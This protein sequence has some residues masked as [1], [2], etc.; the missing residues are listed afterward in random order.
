MTHLP[1]SP[2]PR[3]HVLPAA[4]DS[5]RQVLAGLMAQDGRGNEASDF[6]DS[7]LPQ[8]AASSAPTSPRAKPPT[9]SAS[10]HRE[11]F[12][13][14]SSARTPSAPPFGVLGSPFGV[15]NMPMGSG[16]PQGRPQ[17]RPTGWGMH[18][19]WERRVPGPSVETPGMRAPPARTAQSGAATA[20]T[21]AHI[22]STAHT[23]AGSGASAANG[24]QDATTSATASSPLTSSNTKGGARGTLQVTMNVRPP[25]TVVASPAPSA[26]APKIV[27]YPRPPQPP[28]R[29]SSDRSAASASASGPGGAVRSEKVGLHG[30]QQ[31]VE[32]DLQ[33]PICR[34]N[35]PSHP[36]APQRPGARAA[37]PAP[38]MAHKNGDAWLEAGKRTDNARSCRGGGRQSRVIGGF[39]GGGF[40]GGAACVSASTKL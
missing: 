20:H 26:P 1:P 19:V 16:R 5:W 29:P 38:K 22:T 9:A 10:T 13:R 30:A 24:V 35:P 8:G 27:P 23:A 34:P 33:P 37:R 14:P 39:V 6:I 15:I 40:C 28:P 31:G 21:T 32:E 36:R 17:G 2:L 25:V 12:M 7:L 3:P 11:R 4:A 18:S